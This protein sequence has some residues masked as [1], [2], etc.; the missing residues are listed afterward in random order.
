MSRI[1]YKV[2]PLRGRGFKSVG[3]AYDLLATLFSRLGSAM[4]YARFGRRISGV[5]KRVAD[6]IP[7]PD[8]QHS[9]PFAA[10]RNGFGFRWSGEAGFCGF[11][12]CFSRGGLFRGSG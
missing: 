9:S 2:V 4:V 8:P 5:A 12:V 10:P 11:S 3:A 1:C 6:A 7:R